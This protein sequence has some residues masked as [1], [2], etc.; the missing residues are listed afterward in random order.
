MADMNTP[1]LKATLPK[2]DR[3]N[4]DFSSNVY[5]NRSG[6]NTVTRHPDIC[7][8]DG[9]VA[10]LTGSHYSLVHHG[11]LSR[12]SKVF[13]SLLENL[14]SQNDHSIEGRPMLQIQD[15]PEDMA[16]F[17]KAHYD[18]MYVDTNFT[19]YIYSQPPLKILSYLRRKY[20]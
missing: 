3:M 16:R 2:H 19:H 7:F 8:D 17:L 18:G 14:F 12:H 6:C 11:L 4:S 9:N 5:G 10:I 1:T 20:L 15:S 13:K